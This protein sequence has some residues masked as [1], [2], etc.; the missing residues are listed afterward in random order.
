MTV[1][2]PYLL[3]VCGTNSKRGRFMKPAEV[4]DTIR[5]AVSKAGVEGTITVGLDKNE[6]ADFMWY[7]CKGK[8]DFF[9]VSDIKDLTLFVCPF[10]WIENV[11]YSYIKDWDV[12]DI[13]FTLNFY[14]KC[15]RKL[16]IE[17]DRD[18]NFEKWF[19][20]GDKYDLISNKDDISKYNLLIEKKNVYETLIC[21]LFNKFENG[22][23]D[24]EF[25]E[26]QHSI[27]FDYLMQNKN[28]EEN[29]F[30]Y[31]YKAADCISRHG[32][33]PYFTDIINEIKA[34]ELNDQFLVYTKKRCWEEDENSSFEDVKYSYFQDII[35]IIFDQMHDDNAN[36]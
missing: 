24:M 32:S 33:Y 6:E 25:C 9:V 26:K 4:L 36:F 10:S 27:I 13:I 11:T 1:D 23:V 22:K 15:N 20:Y 34:R 19:Y 21:A 28:D 7:S 16:V 2:I 31:A 8:E 29:L 12:E 3:F 18:F 30:F 14:L 35:T 5:N 17:C